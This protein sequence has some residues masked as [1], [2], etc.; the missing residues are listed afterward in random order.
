MKFL[1][2]TLLFLPQFLFAQVGIN[3]TT[4]QETLHVEGTFCVTNTTTKTPTKLSGLDNNGTLAD[5]VIGDNLE[6][7]GNVLSANVPVSTSSPTI[8]LV[9]TMVIP[10]GPPGEQLNNYDIDL[11]GAHVDKVV[12]RLTGRT[13]NYKITGIS[14]GTDGRHIVLFNVESVNLTLVAESTDSNPENRLI[15][16]ANNVATSGRGTAELVYDGTLQ[17]WILIGFR[18]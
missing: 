15:T 2:F 9:A 13:A 7:T 17:R 5:V 3:T 18:D 4:P 1:I 8:Y 11:G 6:L 14:G 12:F 10:D 16:L